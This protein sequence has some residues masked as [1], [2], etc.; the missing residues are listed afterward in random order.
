MICRLRRWRLTAPRIPPKMAASVL[1]SLSSL[2]IAQIIS[3]YRIL[4]RLGGGGMGVVYKAEDS[5]LGRFVALNLWLTGWMDRVPLPVPIPIQLF[6]AP[7][8]RLLLYSAALALISAIISGLTPALRSTRADVN[9]ALKQEER[10]VGGRRS[11]LRN[12]LV[13]GQLAVSVVLLAAGFLFLRNL[14]KATSMNLG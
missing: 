4:E 2:M 6:I 12:L 1:S 14:L 5:R 10:Q 11:N 7:D 8:W 9:V 13:A 3:H